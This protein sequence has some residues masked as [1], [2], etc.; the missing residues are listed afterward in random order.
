MA[1]SQQTARPHKREG[2]WYL[3]RRVPIEFAALDRRIIVRHCVC[4]NP[5]DSA[6]AVA[7]TRFLS[8]EWSCALA[9]AL[10]SFLSIGGLVNS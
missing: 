9:A 7:R 6:S 5:H 4:S 1:S 8:A 10:L 3:V 2:F